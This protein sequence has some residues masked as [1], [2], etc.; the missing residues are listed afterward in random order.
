M[1][2]NKII[3]NK[4]ALLIGV[5]VIILIVFLVNYKLTGK[6]I[7]SSDVNIMRNLP[8][9]V[10]KSKPFTVKISISATETVTGVI[11]G[12]LVPI[13]CSVASINPIPK[14]QG[15]TGAGIVIGW[16]NITI[17]TQTKILSYIATCSEIGLK[18]FRGKI[19]ILTPA[20]EKLIEGKTS[21]NIIAVCGDSICEGEE[22]QA[23]CPPDCK[24]AAICGNGICEHETE[25]TTTCSA[26]CKP[27]DWCLYE[28]GLQQT[29]GMCK[30]MLGCF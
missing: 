30:Y 7:T 12:E 19:G 29:E 9:N 17:G 21:V 18:T 6:V 14:I 2:K 24:P 27:C 1:A 20:I 8:D 10:N 13:G 26:D 3:D 23:N 25:K 15:L 5:A 22:T 11:V 4:T 16:D 28:G